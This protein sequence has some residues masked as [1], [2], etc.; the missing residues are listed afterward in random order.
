MKLGG[1]WAVREGL[2]HPITRE[3]E[4]STRKHRGSSKMIVAH[5]G[6]SSVNKAENKDPQRHTNVL[7]VGLAST[8]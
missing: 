6:F 3:L 8:M 7:F 4:L 1:P 2:Q 5:R